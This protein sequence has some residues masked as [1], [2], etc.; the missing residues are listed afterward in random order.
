MKGVVVEVVL[1]GVKAC[2]CLVD[3]ASCTRV[4][5]TLSTQESCER[6]EKVSFKQA[7]RAMSEEEIKR[8]NT[9]LCVELHDC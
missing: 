8:G 4:P 5:S 7:R 6:H 3:A 2:T 1:H 9:L